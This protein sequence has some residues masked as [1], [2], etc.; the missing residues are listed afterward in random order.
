MEFT[1]S[2]IREK[3][4]LQ[5][6][7]NTKR[8][9]APNLTALSNRIEVMLE[10][11]RN[12]TYVVR[13]HNMHLCVRMTTRIVQNFQRLGAIMNRVNPHDWDQDWRVT[14]S[15]YERLY[16]TDAWAVV[17]YE[18]KPVF[19]SGEY[20]PFLD[21]I[22]KCAIEHD[23]AYDETIPIAEEAFKSTGKDVKIEYDANVA[24][25]LDMASKQCRSGI[26][27]RGPLRTTTFSFGAFPKEE[28]KAV[29]IPQIMAASAAFLEAV[30]LAFM[31][32]MNNVKIVMGIIERFSTAEKQ[33]REA[34]QRLGKLITEISNMEATHDIRYRPEKPS[35]SE[36]TNS[37]EEIAENTLEPPP[38]K[39]IMME[40]PESSDAGPILD[41]NGRIVHQ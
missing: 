27:H 25:V 41:D 33:T 14:L 22:E 18:G 40:E 29:N 11:Q 19:S 26:I 9:K 35:F 1:A 6:Q 36:I 37:A 12:E 13:A 2:L 32:G 10:G 7:D 8:D 31:V 23:G 28:G 39:P 3:F 21:L 16:N 34:K 5:E 30:Q 38:P 20:H 17:Y 4:V 15:D 24:L